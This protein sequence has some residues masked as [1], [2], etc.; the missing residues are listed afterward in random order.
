M[1]PNVDLDPLSTVHVA[2]VELRIEL[3]FGVADHRVFA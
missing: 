3:G 2:G 1:R